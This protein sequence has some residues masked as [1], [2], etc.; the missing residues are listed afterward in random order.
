MPSMFERVSLIFP[1]WMLFE[2]FPY[3]YNGVVHELVWSLCAIHK[4]DS[5]E[6]STLVDF[7]GLQDEVC[8]LLR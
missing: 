2:K 7:E 5:L 1:R 4:T 3:Q 8:Q 6:G